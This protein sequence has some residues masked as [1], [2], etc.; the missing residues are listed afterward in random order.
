MA[1]IAIQPDDYTLPGAPAEADAASPRWARGLERLGHRVRWVDVRRADVLEQLAGCDGFLWRFAHFAGM[2]AIAR[3]LLPVLERTLGLVIYPS[4][5]SWIAFDDKPAQ[6][7][8]LAAAGIPSP[9]SWT[10][11]DEASALHWLDA[12]NYPLVMKLAGGASSTN[13][14][15]VRTAEEGRILTRQAFRRG[16][17][18]LKGDAALVGTAG[19]LRRALDI[20]DHALHASNQRRCAP[21]AGY[22]HF[23]EFLPGNTFDTRVTVIG[24]RAFAFRRFN[25]PGDFRASGSGHIDWDPAAIDSRCLDL[26]RDTARRLGMES[27]ATD[28][29]YDGEA[30]RIVE[31]SYTFGPSLRLCPGHWLETGTG[32]QW[33]EGRMDPEEA[34]LEGFLARLEQRP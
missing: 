13:V 6:A 12:A 8:A 19:R 2:P 32:W 26:A 27:C 10:W 30:P 29:L 23:Q 33:Q 7:L 24:A 14:R 9:R 31:F 22:V 16:L 28:L 11:Y 21:E 1:T 17:R 5:D 34:Q 4:L 25:R 15:L 20:L 18:R 3:R